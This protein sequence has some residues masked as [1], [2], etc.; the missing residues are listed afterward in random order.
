MSAQLS[1]H[2]SGTRSGAPTRRAEQPGKLPRSARIGLAI[3]AIH[4]LVACASAAAP[5][6]SQHGAAATAAAAQSFIA[7]P[8]QHLLFT[9]APSGAPADAEAY[10]KASVLPVL[11][12][13]PRIGDVAIYGDPRS[14]GYIIEAE[15]RTQSP[16]NLGLA[17]EVL[18]AGTSEDQARQIIAGLAKY[19]DLASVQQL[20]ARADLSVSRRIVG[21]VD[22]GGR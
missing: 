19:F 8:V 1:F 22:G 6:E 7:R 20:T 18:G 16:L 14:G 10:V 12:R 9:A 11:A 17:L 3:I 4:G 2:T 13:D 21:T 15:L 5:S